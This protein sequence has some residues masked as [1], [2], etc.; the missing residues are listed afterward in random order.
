MCLWVGVMPRSSVEE[1]NFIYI[2]LQSKVLRYDTL[3][4]TVA[5]EMRFP[6]SAVDLI[7]RAA[8]LHPPNLLLVGMHDG[9]LVTFDVWNGT[10][11]ARSQKSG[12]IAAIKELVVDAR[13]ATLVSVSDDRTLKLWSV[14]NAIIPLKSLDFNSS[15]F[16]CTHPVSLTLS[17]GFV[18]VGT[19]PDDMTKASSQ[20]GGEVFMFCLITLLNGG[21]DIM[22][23]FSGHPTNVGSVRVQDGTLISVSGEAIFIWNISERTKVAG[24]ESLHSFTSALEITRTRIIS[25][26]SDGTITLWRYQ[27]KVE[28]LIKDLIRRKEKDL[29]LSHC[30]L[31]DSPTILRFARWTTTLNLAN[32]A[33]TSFP[34]VI[35]EC[36]PSLVSLN[37]SYNYLDTLPPEFDHLQHLTMLN[38]D[39]N[40]FRMIPLAIASLNSLKRLTMADNQLSFLMPFLT[41]LPLVTLDV[42]A[43]PLEDPSLE[44]VKMGM[45]CIMDALRAKASTNVVPVNRVKLML[46]GNENVGKT[47]LALNLRW[48]A[49]LFGGRPSIKTLSTQGISIETVQS[50]AVVL[51]PASPSPG[52][53]GSAGTPAATPST[54]RDKLLLSAPSIPKD[55]KDKKKEPKRKVKW[56]TWDFGGQEIYYH[57][58]Q[59][60]ITP[61]S[62]YIIAFDVTKPLDENNLLF[63]LRCIQART[64]T[65]RG[66]HSYSGDASGN[67]TPVPVILVATHIDSFDKA[68]LPWLSDMFLPNSKEK[69]ALM[70]KKDEGFLEVYFNWIYS[71]FTT[72][73]P[74]I[75]GVMGVSSKT[76]KGV[77]ELKAALKDLYLTSPAIRSQVNT[78]V[79]E[80]VFMLEQLIQRAK[81]LK[82]PPILTWREYQTMASGIIDD[83]TQLLEATKLLA[84]LGSLVYLP[85][86]SRKNSWMISMAQLF[87]EDYDSSAGATSAE[88]IVLDP[89]WLVDLFATI[90]GTSPNFV[91][92]GLIRSA[93]LALIWR[94]F[95]KFPPALHSQLMQI[96]EHFDVAFSLSS[97][98]KHVVELNPVVSG[99][100]APKLKDIPRPNKT[101]AG[102]K[103][104]S[105]RGGDFTSSL[106]LNEAPTHLFP[107]LLPSGKPHL[108]ILWPAHEHRFQ[109]D[110]IYTFPRFLPL[111]LFSRF[112]V[113]LLSYFPAFY[114]WRQGVVISDDTKRAYALVEEI[115]SENKVVITVRGPVNAVSQ[116]LTCVMDIWG[117]LVSD[118][119]DISFMMTT[120]CYH[121]TSQR[122]ENPHIFHLSDCEILVAQ[123]ER[124]CHCGHGGI[125]RLDQ[126]CPDLCL[127]N[128]RALEIDPRDLLPWD[129]DPPDG[130]LVGEGGFGFV[131]RKSY[132]GKMVAVKKFKEIE[133]QGISPEEAAKIHTSFRNEIWLMS[134]ASHPNIVKLIGFSLRRESIMVMEYISGGDLYEA[135]IGDKQLT[136]PLRYR[137]AL[138]IARGM[139]ALHALNPPLCHS[140]LKCPN[141]MIV[142]WNAKANVVA[143]VSDFGLSSRLYGEQL[144]KTPTMNPFW[145]AP[146]ILAELPFDTSADVYSFGVIL[147]NLLSRKALFEELLP[148]TDDVSR[149]VRA[150]KRPTIPSEKGMLPE[151]EVL[152]RQCWDHKPASRPKFPQICLEL[153]AMIAKHCP[154]LVPIVEKTRAEMTTTVN[155]DDII[156]ST[157]T[158]SGSTLDIQTLSSLS[159]S[160]LSR[161]ASNS[162]IRSSQITRTWVELPEANA[163]TAGRKIEKVVGVGS[164]GSSDVAPT[165]YNNSKL[166]DYGT[167]LLKQLKLGSVVTLMT[168]V[169]L[170]QVWAFSPAMGLIYV[171]NSVSGQ[172]VKSFVAPRDLECLIEVNAQEGVSEVWAGGLSGLFIWHGDTAQPL[173]HMPSDAP[174]RSL[175][176]IPRQDR[177]SVVWAGLNNSTKIQVWSATTRDL[178]KTVDLGIHHPDSRQLTQSSPSLHHAKD[179]DVAHSNPASR[180]PSPRHH[181]QP[182]TDLSGIQQ[183]QQQQVRLAPPLKEPSPHNTQSQPDSSQNAH[184]RHHHSKSVG[185]ASLPPDPLAL[186]LSSLSASSTAHE[187]PLRSAPGTAS[188]NPSPRQPAVNLARHTLQWGIAAMIRFNEHVWVAAGPYL[189][190]LFANTAKPADSTFESSSDRLDDLVDSALSTDMTATTA[191]S[192]SSSGQSS[193]SQL[194]Q[195]PPKLDLSALSSLESS[196]SARSPRPFQ[197]F[198]HSGGITSMAY[199]RLK[200]LWTCGLDGSMK[201]WDAEEGTLIKSVPDYCPTQ[202][203]IVDRTQLWATKPQG[204]TVDT[205]NLETCE[206]VSSVDTEHKGNVNRT[207]LVFNKTVWTAG[208]DEAIHVFT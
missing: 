153:E 121:C 190:R 195:K 107:S 70:A 86:S 15:H 16:G 79:Y 58:H 23:R 168:S 165:Y 11:L 169:G 59:F 106:T 146:E 116:F 85:S 162:A 199:S 20:R 52:V 118:M 127:V 197:F 100:P 25:A 124:F 139:A 36:L 17:G 96:L 49:S 90:L 42:S 5:R 147:W 111:G 50:K 176:F 53:S 13:S 30:Q 48:K 163:K 115:A 177:R 175:L 159:I 174:I 128:I 102:A 28:Q 19:K 46:V 31:S 186:G 83:Q 178:L 166:A 69:I 194:S 172:F 141:C 189:L 207:L 29:D 122:V 143:K 57:T 152:I 97:R 44:V 125:V 37:L 8:V 21:A 149:A 33:F 3:T 142:D 145:T 131:F 167:T 200:R 117:K 47:S 71:K 160:P 4:R 45:Q 76:G 120:T 18:F 182:R 114:Y 43:N 56:Y 130:G 54:P 81:S 132:K 95:A 192:A 133:K 180:I 179:I 61:H 40:R 188:A 203:L 155:H 7:L 113:R 129:R 170:S 196:S 35:A 198:A 51:P 72:E 184:S 2:G 101:S 82:M 98:R 41:R 193:A 67:R 112:M 134:G 10:I 38:L 66:S 202:L 80:R 89:Q 181:S 136:W 6:L 204:P 161:A 104:L 34:A 99:L 87:P 24:I 201:I 22:A 74:N 1:A 84:N 26:G 77:K 208:Q 110:R 173:S 27:T 119:Y 105:P 138:D 164:S 148:W 65:S 154:E 68:T 55:T 191:S 156:R 151:Y 94:D 14:E 75:K 158:G 92:N 78:T 150:G 205:W 103:L 187:A 144:T 93:D 62:I 123:G 39:H 183:H 63:W 108:D 157:Y 73:H 88:F 12:H 140:D 171:I 32:N 9:T 64:S 135:L 91:R 137:I 109:V 206:L 185:G 60:F 126:L